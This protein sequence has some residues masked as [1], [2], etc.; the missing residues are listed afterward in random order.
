MPLEQVL[1]KPLEVLA[2]HRGAASWQG[3]HG[4]GLVPGAEGQRTAHLQAGSCPRDS[5]FSIIITWFLP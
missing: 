5:P 4:L 2:A 3:L 1:R